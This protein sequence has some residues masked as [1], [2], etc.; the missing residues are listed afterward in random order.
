MLRLL[1][2]RSL[3]SRLPSIKSPQLYA[4]A[5]GATTRLLST[6]PVTRSNTRSESAHE[7]EKLNAL[8]KDKIGH[9][10]QLDKKIGEKKEVCSLTL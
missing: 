9:I 6:T 7:I 3:A 8:V 2:T 4:V 1:N 10:D 5:T